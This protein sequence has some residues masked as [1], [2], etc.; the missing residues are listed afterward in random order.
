[1]SCLENDQILVLIFRKMSLLQ[2][3]TNLNN[4]KTKSDNYWI[5]LFH[6]LEMFKPINRQWRIP[7]KKATPDGVL[8]TMLSSVPDAWNLELRS[9]NSTP[10]V[11]TGAAVSSTSPMLA[12]NFINACLL[13]SLFL[14]E[15]E[16][17]GE[18]L[19]TYY[20]PNWMS[21]ASKYFLHIILWKFFFLFFKNRTMNLLVS[22]PTLHNH[23]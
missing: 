19:G 10:M 11:E 1:M 8:A 7:A 17:N 20:S 16:I 3:I 18:W 21:A 22:N 12:T 2:H 13:E 9:S 4:L 23:Q 5:T 15:S 14:L 6:I